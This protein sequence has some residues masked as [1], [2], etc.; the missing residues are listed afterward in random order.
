MGT[1]TASMDH[2]LGDA[3]VIEVRDL[4]AEVMVL[5]ERGSAAPRPQGVLGGA[6]AGPV[7]GGEELALLGSGALGSAGLLS[8]GRASLRGGLI[9]LGRQRA[10]RLGGL[11][12]G[13]RF[14]ARDPWHLR[15]LGAVI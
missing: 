10:A 13:C 3:L 11:L 14:G 5:Q 9:G 8:G 2:P 4:L 12:R 7:R 6:Q 15:K 1:G